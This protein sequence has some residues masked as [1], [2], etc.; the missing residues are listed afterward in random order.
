MLLL[1][2]IAL[3]PNA[4][5]AADPPSASAIS[6]LPADV[7]YFGST[8]RMGETVERIGKSQAWKQIWDDPAVQEFRKKLQEKLH[9]EEL[10]PV[11]GFFADPANA[12]IPALAADAFANEFFFY[13]GAGTGEFLALIEE[14]GGAACYGPALM[15]LQG[16]DNGDPKNAS[17]CSSKCWRG[18]QNRDGSQWQRPHVEL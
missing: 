8:L 18:N 12:E 10:A 7:E 16:Q 17:A 5:R 9:G 14:F 4:S 3:L 13:T 2:A 11:R 6:K 15:Q 1:F